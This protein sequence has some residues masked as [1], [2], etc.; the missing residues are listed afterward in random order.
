MAGDHS[1]VFAALLSLLFHGATSFQQPRPFLLK[2][3]G[4][5]RDLIARSAMTTNT[6]TISSAAVELSRRRCLSSSAVA[7]ATA[8]AALSPRTAVAFCG[9][10]PPDWAY[11]LQFNEGLVPAVQTALPMKGG[12]QIFVRLVGDEKKELASKVRPVVLIPGG[13]GVPHNYL[14]TMDAIAKTDRQVLS[15]DPLGCGDSVPA[16]FPE[17]AFPSSEAVVVAAA[18]PEALAAQA[19][20]AVEGVGLLASSGGGKGGDGNGRGGGGGGGGG[21]GLFGGGASGA[22]GSSGSSSVGRTHHVWGHGTGAAAALLYA[23][24]RPAGEVLSLTLAS[25]IFGAPPAVLTTTTSTSTSTST[26][27]ASAEE[28]VFAWA[29]TEDPAVRGSIL[30]KPAS[31]SSLSSGAEKP[32]ACVAEAIDGG[33]GGRRVYEAWRPADVAKLAAAAEELATKGSEIA[34]E[35][36]GAGGFW[37]GGGTPTLLTLGAHDLEEVRASLSLAKKL[38]ARVA[39]GTTAAAM[40]TP[41]SAAGE[42]GAAT[43][44]A[45]APPPQ[46]SSS[47]SSSRKAA[48][49]I[50]ATYAESGH[51]AH[52][53]EREKYISDMFNFL[54]IADARTKAA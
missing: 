50:T 48:P 3:V 26:S 53:D 54:D 45:K 6:T 11:F 51:L 30:Y 25:P 2:T 4:G 16:D 36:A 31:S 47:S 44:T 8:M 41:G 32:V 40:A 1:V 35:G 34:S 23:A 9:E 38:L 22:S 33:R 37:R 49:A 52:L 5:R 13:P 7:A 42:E 21:G 10:R 24:S 43:T 15:F 19:A 20:A 29:A 18:S 46:G 14:E 39:A 12:A 28:G 27:P 17:A